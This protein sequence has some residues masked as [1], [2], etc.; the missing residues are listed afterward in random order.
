MTRGR[1]AAV[2]IGGE[3][4]AGGNDESQSTAAGLV[5]ILKPAATQWSLGIKA[6]ARRQDG[7]TGAYAGIELGYSF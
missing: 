7:D 4:L 6:G 2:S 1:T 5:L 3:V